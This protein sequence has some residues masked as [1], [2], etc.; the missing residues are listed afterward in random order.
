MKRCS[1][2]MVRGECALCELETEIRVLK[3]LEGNAHDDLNYIKGE[4]SKLKKEKSVMV[5]KEFCDRMVEAERSRANRLEQRVHELVLENQSLKRADNEL[6]KRMKGT[7][8]E[9]I[10]GIAEE[11][12][13][14]TALLIKTLESARKVLRKNEQKEDQEQED[15]ELP[16]L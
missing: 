4:N 12:N 3:T 1:H 15:E 5:T 2:G 9:E 13:R 14:L 11:A 8:E 6:R 16:G 10:V 7:T